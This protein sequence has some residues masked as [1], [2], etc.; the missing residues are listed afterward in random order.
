MSYQR[1]RHSQLKAAAL[2][3]VTRKSGLPGKRCYLCKV[4][5]LHSSAYHFHHLIP[6]LKTA[7][8]STLISKG[9]L[10][11]E[12]LDKCIVLCANCHAEVTN[13]NQLANRLVKE[14]S[15]GL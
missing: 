3:Y 9:S 1:A 12:E 7:N 15:H 11:K 13:D 5:H 10:L 8:I 14:C 2:T 4:D 6:G